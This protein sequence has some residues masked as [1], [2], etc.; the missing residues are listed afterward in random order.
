MKG[1]WMVKKRRQKFMDKF[2]DEDFIRL[3]AD[4]HGAAI[5]AFNNQHYLESGVIYHQLVE[6]VIRLAIHL[7]A[8]RAG[9]SESVIRRMEKEQS[10]YQL[11]LFLDL[12][13]PNNSLSGRLQ[14]FNKHRN[15]F[16][17]N[18][19]SFNSIK[20][21]ETVFRT[22]CLEGKDLTHHLLNLVNLQEDDRI[23]KYQKGGEPE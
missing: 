10:F 7:L 21:L 23:E 1:G 14:N 4:L 3:S 16:M 18:L 2:L 6:I 11:I 20:S 17:H 12:I 8:I 22:F 5:R 15:D 19:F 9:L 13:K